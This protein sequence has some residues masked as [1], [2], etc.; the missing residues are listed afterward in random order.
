MFRDSTEENLAKEIY[1]PDDR[2]YIVR[3]L[4][5]M[6]LT[7][8]SR[9]TTNDC[10]QVAKALVRKFPFLKE[11]V[12][13]C[14]GVCLY[15]DII[16]LVIVVSILAILVSLHLCVMPKRESKTSGRGN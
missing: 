2:K 7:T 12:S 14:K 10:D 11:Y 13:T 9:A 16:F 6:I 4:G 15:C 8:G 3:L 5:T 1:Y